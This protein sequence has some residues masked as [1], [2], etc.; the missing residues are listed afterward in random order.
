M[1]HLCLAQ[2]YPALTYYHEN[3]AE[4]EAELVA[5]ESEYER[6]IALNNLPMQ[7]T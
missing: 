1:D 7:E 6:W 2:V 5:E 3:R 4:I